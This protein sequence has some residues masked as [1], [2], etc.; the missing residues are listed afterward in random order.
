MTKWLLAMVSIYYISDYPQRSNLSEKSQI[1]PPPATLPNH[2]RSA[3][4]SHAFRRQPSV[5]STR[6]LDEMKRFARRELAE[7]YSCLGLDARWE[8]VR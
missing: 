3:L 1:L 6:P 2:D 7:A 8:K 5:Q 4:C